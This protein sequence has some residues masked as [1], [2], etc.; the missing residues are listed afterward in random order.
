MGLIEPLSGDPGIRAALAGGTR[1]YL[2]SPGE[3]FLVL[4]G[5]RAFVWNPHMSPLS[6]ALAGP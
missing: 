4:G 1:G 6:E 5:T 3:N 2:F